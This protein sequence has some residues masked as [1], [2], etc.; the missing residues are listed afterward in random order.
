MLLIKTEAIKPGEV[1]LQILEQDINKLKAE[2]TGVSFKKSIKKSIKIFKELDGKKINATCSAK[3]IVNNCAAIT[4]V[5]TSG[6]FTDKNM[7]AIRKN[8]KDIFYTINAFEDAKQKLKFGGSPIANNEMEFFNRLLEELGNFQDMITSLAL[9]NNER[10]NPLSTEEREELLAIKEIFC[11][12]KNSI[13]N[14]IVVK[15]QN[16]LMP[17]LRIFSLPVKI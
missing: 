7:H 5:I 16:E 8:L 3:F 13:K 11:A 6:N 10:L 9:L 4:T 14:R 15:L 12:E 2:L 17:H 1:Y